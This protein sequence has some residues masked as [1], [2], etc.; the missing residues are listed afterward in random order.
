MADFIPEWKSKY[1][2]KHLSPTT[3]ARYNE[4]IKLRI[5]PAIGHMRMD[6]V[7]PLHI[8][9]FLEKLQMDG[10][11]GDGKERGLS[12]GSVQYYHRVLKNIFSRAV[13]WRIIK[14]N[15]VSSIKKPKVVQKQT[16]VYNK[17]N[18]R[19]LFMALEK[20]PLMWQVFIKLVLTTGMRRGELLGLEW[21]HVDLEEGIVSVKQAIT[22]MKDTGYDIKE[23]KTQN[24]VRKLSLPVPVLNE[25]KKYRKLSLE[26]RMKTDDMWEGGEWFFLFTATNGKSL[27]PSSVYTWWRRFIEKNNLPYIRFH[28]LRHTS[29]TLL[30]NQGAHIKTISSRLGHASISTTMNTYG[31]A[32]EEADKKAADM[33][34]SLFDEEQKKSK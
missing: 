17:K 30:I 32:L 10:A 19:F 6:K 26:N 28:D 24:S 25:L 21:E 2:V 5:I 20:E 8:L 3:M 7:K 12:S 9:D 15:P 29:A 31:H 4:M 11:R 34:N 13:E 22:Y 18:V 27:N 14:D 33:F 1:A 16:E 23:P